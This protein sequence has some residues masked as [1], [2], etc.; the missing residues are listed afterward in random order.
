MESIPASLEKIYHVKSY[1]VDIN[2][3]LMPSSV[4]NYF[5]EIAWEHAEILKIGY[6]ALKSI[7]RFWVL[8][9]LQIKFYQYPQWTDEV[10]LITWP[11]GIDGMFAL[12][13]YL[14][15]S[16]TGEKQ[17]AAASSWLILDSEK[18]RPQR[19]DSPDHPEF[20]IN[21]T[22]AYIHAP[23]K[24]GKPDNYS[25]SYRNTVK[26]SDIDVNKHVNNVKYIQWALDSISEDL[27]NGELIDEMI[28]N[29]MAEASLGNEVQINV[30]KQDKL[31]QI[32][33]LNAS[34]NK[35]LCRVQF[36]YK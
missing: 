5:Q 13:D 4:C 18:H 9:R 15:F 16:S 24:I 2:A 3:H 31:I 35:E 28:V 23:V 10:K 33:M 26:Y 21:D 19:I 11:K 30:C 7:H 34:T 6:N 25:Q 36:Q 12:R 22:D 17:V 32:G 1:E 27:I 14:M 20:K 29:F 8:S